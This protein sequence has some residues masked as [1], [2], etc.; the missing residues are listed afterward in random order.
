MSTKLGL[1][2]IVCIQLGPWKLSVIQSSGVSA[3]QGLLKYWNGRTVGTFRIVC[4]IVGVCCWG[5]SVKQGFTVLSCPLCTMKCC[6]VCGRRWSWRQDCKFIPSSF[7]LWSLSAWSRPDGCRVWP[8]YQYQLWPSLCVCDTDT[9]SDQ[10]L[11][12]SCDP[13]CVY[14]RDHVTRGR[15]H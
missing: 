14:G 8:Q 5:V 2:S 9:A 12:R 7:H 10:R 13:P 3:F 4:Y 6:C 1:L 15:P 11:E